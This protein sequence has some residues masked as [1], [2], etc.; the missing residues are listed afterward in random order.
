MPVLDH[1]ENMDD[2][3]YQIYLE[4]FVFSH[5]EHLVF[6]EDAKNRASLEKSISRSETLA[7]K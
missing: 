5:P 3:L 6:I 7:Y 2:H 1:E 4:N